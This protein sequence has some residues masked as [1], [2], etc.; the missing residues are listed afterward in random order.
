MRALQTKRRVSMML[1]AAVAIAALGEVTGNGPLL[2]GGGEAQAVIGRPATPFSYA[3]VA[4]RT[5]RRTVA[6]GAY[7][8]AVGIHPYVATGMVTALPGGCGPL[9]GGVYTCGAVR[10]QPYYSGPTLVYAAVP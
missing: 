8:A 6:A 10:Y 3:G 1:A 9:V 5:T 2:L 7:P 4:R